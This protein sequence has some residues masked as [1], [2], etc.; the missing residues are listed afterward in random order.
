VRRFRTLHAHPQQSPGAWEWE[1][2][3]SNP[4]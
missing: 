1:A 2:F 3:A 4:L